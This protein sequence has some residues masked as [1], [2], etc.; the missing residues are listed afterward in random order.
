MH[1]LEILFANLVW[2]G[3]MHAYSWSEL[4]LPKIGMLGIMKI[5]DI[6]VAAGQKFIWNLCTNQSLWALWIMARYCKSSI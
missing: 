6:N 2:K 4:C 5:S 1:R 3:K